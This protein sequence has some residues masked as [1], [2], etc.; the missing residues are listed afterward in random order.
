MLEEALMKNHLMGMFIGLAVGD[1]LGRPIEG[2]DPRQVQ[3]MED[4]GPFS[5]SL[6]AGY[7]TDDTS[8]ALCL[9]DSLLEQGRYDSYDV[10]QRYSRWAAQGYRSSTGVCF[11]IGGQVRRAL[12]DFET[13]PEVGE[14]EPRTERAGNGCIMRL[15]P[16]VI[17]A[18]AVGGDVGWLSRM[19][20]RETHYSELAEDATE[21]FGEMLERAAT[22]GAQG[23]RKESIYPSAG[24]NPEL[25]RRLHA[26]ADKSAEELTPS[27]FVVDT[28]EAALWAFMTAEDF[29]A[30]AL[31]AV[32]LGGDADTI[33][34]VYGQ[35]AGAYYGLTEIPAEWRGALHDYEEL[36]R[37]AEALASLGSLSAPRTRFAED[38]PR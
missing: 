14:T 16:V 3:G 22:A 1:A 6:P 10:M 27:G 31:K 17:A 2:N 34:A 4:G 26:A 23:G 36:L 30:G 38:N 5:L 8:M 9:S 11:D 18:L 13:A 19:S 20:G 35:L 24:T 29:A 28:L 33:G 12:A 21:I 32:N 7:W 15:A 37:V 25:A